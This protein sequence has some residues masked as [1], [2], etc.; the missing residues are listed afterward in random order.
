MKDKNL[1]THYAFVGGFFGLHHYYL[2]EVIKGMMRTIVALAA[3]G[4]SCFA[5]ITWHSMVFLYPLLYL[6]LGNIVQ[7]VRLNY[8]DKDDFEEEYNEYWLIEEEEETSAALIGVA[9]EIHKLNRLFEK[10]IITFE[11][12]EHRKVKLLQ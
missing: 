8:M 1:A 4:L 6:L 12:F 2:G 10:G 11:E 9:E 5:Y 7:G 3:L